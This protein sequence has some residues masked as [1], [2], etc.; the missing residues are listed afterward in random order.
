MA[1]YGLEGYALTSSRYQL[2]EES[3]EED[4]ILCHLMYSRSDGERLYRRTFSVDA[5]TGEVQSLSSS[6]P[7][8][9]DRTPALT[10]EEAQA[11]AEAFLASYYGAH[12]SHLALYDSSA[13]AAE[14]APFYSFTFARQENGIFF[15]EDCYTVGIDVTDGSVSGLNFRYHEAVSF[16]SPEGIVD[17]D[18]AQSAWMGTYEVSLSYLLVPRPLEDGDPAEARLTQL[19]LTHFY[20]LELGYALE[21]REGSW[22]GVDARTGDPIQSTHTAE[23]GPSYHDLEG[24]WA[25]EAVE[26]LAQYGVGYASSRF[27]PDKALTQ[28][29]LVCLLASTRGW[30]LL[31]P[32]QA[33]AQE[34]DEAYSAVYRMGALKRQDREDI[35]LLTRGDVVQMLLDAAGYGRVAR[36]EGIFT[37]SFSDRAAIPDSELGYAALAQALGLA[38]GT[39][40]GE[41]T[42][43]RAEAAVML[44]RLLAG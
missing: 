4:Q 40:A 19:G 30:L 32:E 28:A 5:C 41:R 18:T 27:Q 16:Q 14:G 38:Q 13:A 36:L 23:E 42:A 9:E 10:L 6:A 15:P 3:D 33:S 12:A 24:H 35:R 20:G 21:R 29:D 34:L 22:I 44:C 31:D 37:C 8:D 17:A 25:Q 7:W 1:E 39:Y 26:R 11:Q 2:L 43:T